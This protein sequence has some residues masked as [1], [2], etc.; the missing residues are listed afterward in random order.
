MQASSILRRL[1]FRWTLPWVMLALYLLVA[2]HALMRELFPA[3]PY[4]PWPDPPLGERLVTVVNL[5]AVLLS[6][7]VEW[8]R[9]TPDS[10]KVLL[11]A[12]LFIP[13][14][15]YAVGRCLDT[16]VG[17]LERRARKP[18]TGLLLHA[19]WVCFGLLLLLAVAPV[20]LFGS[21]LP[22]SSYLG[23]KIEVAVVCIVI[24]AWP[25]FAAFLLWRRLRLWRKAA[26][27]QSGVE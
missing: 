19:T 13:V 14:L 8:T 1:G 18:P 26:Q 6:T 20:F 25:V 4:W 15:W 3:Y 17:L 21:F 10:F 23:E 27:H 12:C 2:W 11:V 7:L 5:P 9:T 24:A 16:N 22:V